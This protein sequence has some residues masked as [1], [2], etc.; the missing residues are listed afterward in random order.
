MK[1]ANFDMQNFLITFVLFSAVMVT[2]GSIAFTMSE[3][4][5]PLGSPTVNSSFISTYNKLDTINGDVEGIQGKMS[6]INTNDYG[7]GVEVFGDA[8]GALKLF[9][10]SMIYSNELIIN[11]SYVLGIDPIWT[12]ALTTIIIILVLTT[13]LFM[14]IKYR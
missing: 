12:T 4:Y 9:F 10:N 8:L 14:V 3:D 13:V 2:F 5:A 11:M 6:N 1:K 7:T